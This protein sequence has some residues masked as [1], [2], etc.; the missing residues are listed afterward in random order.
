VLTALVTTP[1][2]DLLEPADVSPGERQ[3]VIMVFALVFLMFGMGGAAIAQS[4]VT[5]KQTRI[6]E[7]LVSTIPVRAMLAGKIAG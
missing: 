2:V 5:E 3:L 1:P 7:I 4:T 6:V